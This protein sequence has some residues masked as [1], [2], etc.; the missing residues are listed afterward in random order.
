MATETLEA[1]APDFIHVNLLP[2]EYRVVKK[3]YSWL[4]DMRILVPV[5]A[6]IAVVAAYFI[7]QS[8]FRANLEGKQ[9]QLEKVQQEIGANAYVGS[10]IKELEKLRD[11]KTAKN[12]SLKSISVSKKKWVRILE[13]INKSLPLNMWIESIK[14][15]EAN[16]NELEVK[17]RTYIFPEIAE[18]MIELEKNEYFS[19]VFLNGIELQKDQARTSFLY[20]VRINLNPNVGI[21]ALQGMIPAATVSAP[22]QSGGPSAPSP[23]AQA[24]AAAPGAAERAHKAKPPAPAAAAKED[25]A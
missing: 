5:T 21:E 15:S 10:R 24:P 4:I 20:T 25:G 6:I 11:E 17:G 16:D 14:Q 7:G 1:K 9:A 22:D 13:G 2:I 23:A 3:D 18:Y 12:N 19:K 8:F